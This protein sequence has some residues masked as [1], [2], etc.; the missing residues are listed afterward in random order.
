MLPPRREL[1]PLLRR[2]PVRCRAGAVQTDGRPVMTILTMTALLLLAVP[3]CSI[4]EPT[5]GARTPAQLAA[6][7]R[8]VRWWQP[9]WWVLCVTVGAPALALWWTARSTLFNLSALAAWLLAKVASISAADGRRY[10]LTRTDG[11]VALLS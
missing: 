1:L 4:R 2:M 9:A 3:A 5:P 8:A 11:W 7:V 10:R 6:I